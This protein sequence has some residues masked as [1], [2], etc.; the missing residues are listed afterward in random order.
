[1]IIIDEKDL[2]KEDLTIREVIS[3]LFIHY[4]GDDFEEI[5]NDLMG[6]NQVID[7]YN[8]HYIKLSPKGE[9]TIKLFMSGHQSVIE[10]RNNIELAKKMAEIFPKMLKPGT[11]LY[12]RSNPKETSKKLEKFFEQYGEYTEEQILQATRNYVEMKMAN[13]DLKTMRVLKYFIWKDD[14]KLDDEGN[15]RITRKSELADCLEN[16]DSDDDFNLEEDML[17]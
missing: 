11:T 16:L 2:K 6:K 4:V 14:E 5:I 13:N 10:K 1:M 8:N 9:E 12:F 17:R 7:Y 3:M 15:L